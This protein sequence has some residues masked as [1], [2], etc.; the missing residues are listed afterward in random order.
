MPHNARLAIL[1]V[2]ELALKTETTK[3]LALTQLPRK[4]T[5]CM[6][7]DRLDNITQGI[8]RMRDDVSSAALMKELFN[9]LLAVAYVQTGEGLRKSSRQHIVHQYTESSLVVSRNNRVNC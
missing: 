7:L 1:T 6:R 5:T 8:C 9:L 3:Y 4:Q 2:V